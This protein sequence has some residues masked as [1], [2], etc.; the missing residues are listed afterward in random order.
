MKPCHIATFIVMFFSGAASASALANKNPLTWQTILVHD[1]DSCD[2]SQLKDEEK[3]DSQPFYPDEK[4]LVYLDNYFI[5]PEKLQQIREKKKKLYVEPNVVMQLKEQAPPN[6]RYFFSDLTLR[7]LCAEIDQQIKPLKEALRCCNSVSIGDFSQIRL[8]LREDACL[9]DDPKYEDYGW[10]YFIF[11][12]P[13]RQDLRGEEMKL[14]YTLQLCCERQQP[15][16]ERQA[17]TEKLTQL[18]KS[19]ATMT[20]LL[21]EVAKKF[22]HD[23]NCLYEERDRMEGL[24]DYHR[25]LGHIIQAQ[26]EATLDRD[27]RSE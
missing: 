5:S 20:Y 22:Y 15:R 16:A 9:L 11:E 1:T 2:P 23:V 13:A 19:Y 27:E 18:Q 6:L 8:H 12:Q 21:Q 3:P 14:A 10:A 7:K 26:H 25:N 24:I 4:N 17:I